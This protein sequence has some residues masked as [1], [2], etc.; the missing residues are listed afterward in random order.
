MHAGA[1]ENAVTQARAVHRGGTQ[2]ARRGL[3]S[4]DADMV[5]QLGDHSV[6]LQ[7][8][9]ASRKLSKATCGT[10]LHTQPQLQLPLPTLLTSSASAIASSSECCSA[11]VVALTAPSMAAAREEGLNAIF[12]G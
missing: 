12:D 9:E 5:V 2:P 7:P 1:S 3:R 8:E 11:A 10:Q 4:A 6:M